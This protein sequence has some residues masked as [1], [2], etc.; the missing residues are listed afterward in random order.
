MF[1]DISQKE[2][3]VTASHVWGHTPCPR[4]LESP[5]E[6]TKQELNTA[7]TVDTMDGMSYNRWT[8]S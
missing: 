3:H 4:D 7:H 8:Q 5:Y 2:C 6:A 1:I